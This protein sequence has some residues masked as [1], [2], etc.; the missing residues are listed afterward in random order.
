MTAPR[1]VKQVMDALEAWAP[2]PWAYDWDA[3]GLCTGN[4]GARVSRVLVCLTVTR[5]AFNA[6]RE[7]G[8]EMVVSH[9][10]LL[11]KPLK[12]LRSDVP[13][14]KLCLDIAQA[15]IACFSAHTNLDVAPGGVNHALAG[16]LG[17]RETRPLI[18]APN[19]GRV[20]LVA[21]VPESHLAAVRE[22]V[23][24]AGAGVMG[25]YTHCTYSGAGVGTFVPGA[26]SSPFSGERGR[27]AEE[28]ERRFETLVPR[29]R[30]GDVLRAL[31]AAHPYEEPAFDVYPVE[32]HDPAIGLG[33]RGVL[34]EPVPLDAFAA[35]V[36]AALGTADVRVVG[37]GD[38]RVSAVGV[39]G[40]A[41]GSELESLPFDLDVCVT[42]DVSYHRALGALDRGLCLIDA[43]HAATERVIVPRIAAYLHEQLPALETRVY[44]EPPVFKTVT[45][46]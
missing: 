4:P 28:P 32:G 16:L 29:A 35:Q 21:F 18:P 23:C 37:R 9:H 31:Q 5:E 2:A 46:A 7:A 19:A 10:P 27:L 41:G 43:G 24:A 30:L 3:V 36:C 17:L 13:L 45:G 44:E 26:A 12:N 38:K 33:L 39:I 6:A 25:D 40:G 20:K 22:A 11:F 14:T 15:G 1:T 8:A 42:G 34:P